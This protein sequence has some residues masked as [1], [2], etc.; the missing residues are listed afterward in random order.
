MS[1]TSPS[2]RLE[3]MPIQNGSR[4]IYELLIDFIRQ[5]AELGLKTYKTYLQAHNGRDALVDALQ[6][7]VDLNQYLMQMV[8]EAESQR[9]STIAENQRLKFAD[10]I[11]SFAVECHRRSRTAGW[12]STPELSNIPT[13]L[14]LIHSE[15][16]EGM[17]GFRKG[18]M[19]DHLPQRKMIEV[20]LADAMI[21]IGDLAAALNLDLGGAI[22]EKLEYNL[23][24]EDHKAEVRNAAGGKTF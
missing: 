13:K 9:D 2:V 24:R 23:H 17:E 19:D 8:V 18:L 20:E 4:P 7:S 10:S 11:N 1:E 21:R 15:I 14:C 16:S 22:D 3:P 6:E 12:W 5:R